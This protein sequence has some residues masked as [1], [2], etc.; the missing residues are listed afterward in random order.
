[1]KNIE[2]NQEQKSLQDE[3]AEL[4]KTVDVDSQEILDKAVTIKEVKLIIKSLK[5]RKAK[6]F[7][8]VLK[9]GN[10]PSAWNT[11]FQAP[12]F[13]KGDPL[14]CDYYRGISITSC[15]GKV[16]TSLLAERVQN[17]LSTNN[18][19]S[20]Y[21]AAFRKKHGTNDHIFILKT[22]ITKYVKRLKLNLYCCFI[23]FRKAFDSVWRNGL[24]HH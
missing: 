19:L 11:N 18:K 17:F 5:N 3:L 9:S 21:Q 16:F 6:L 4:E 2:L 15:L 24:L 10:F 8:L 7:N 1:M 13:E 14:S 20:I 12:L 23:D 22:L